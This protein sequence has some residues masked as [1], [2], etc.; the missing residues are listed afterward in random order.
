MKVALARFI[1]W[2]C[3]FAE[4]YPKVSFALFGALSIIGLTVNFAPVKGSHGFTNLIGGCILA[5]G[6]QF[7][8]Y[9]M[10]GYC[11]RRERLQHFRTI[12][13]K[14]DLH[15]KFPEEFERIVAD[16]Y[17][18]RGYQVVEQGGYDDGGIDV[19]ARKGDDTL[20]VQCKKYRNWKT[21]IS[22]LRELYGAMADCKAPGRG[23]FVTSGGISKHA[24]AYAKRHRIE[25]IDGNALVKIICSLNGGKNSANIAP[26]CPKCDGSMQ[27]AI[28][29]VGRE[30]GKTLWQ[31][32]NYPVC[33]GYLPV[34]KLAA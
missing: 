8:F 25:V 30:A 21:G 15:D 3:R 24:A 5:L 28:G 11:I 19:I 23:V 26:N 27:V 13:I 18:L 10:L 7:F 1:E 9:G 2:G 32:Q 16:M 22:K 31:C 12:R 4:K 33:T 6:T 17:K 14:Q 20:Y 29:K 34:A